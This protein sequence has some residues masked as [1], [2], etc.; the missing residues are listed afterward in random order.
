MRCSSFSPSFGFT[1]TWT[2]LCSAGLVFAMGCPVSAQPREP[3]DPS[4]APVV[5]SSPA[6]AP[7]KRAATQDES[8][9]FNALDLTRP[10][11]AAVA[12]AVNAGDYDAASHAWAVYLRERKN[13]YWGGKNPV[14][15]KKYNVKAADNAVNGKVQGGMVQY[16]YAF[17]D[18]KID[19]LY[20][21]TKDNPGQ[22]FNHEWQW[23]L[24][25]MSFWN[26]MANAYYFTK[27]ERYPK[28]FAQQLHSWM[29]QCPVPAKAK[30][31]PFDAWR[32]IEAGIRMLGSFPYT[33][34]LMLPS[35]SL[36]DADIVA[37]TR[38]VYDHSHYL[39]TNETSGNWLLM[40]MNGLCTAG[41][42]FPEFRDAADW[43]AHAFE[44][45]AAEAK[46]QLLPDGAQYELSTGYHPDVVISN[47]I[48]IRETAI[49]TGHDNEVP[50]S[51]LASIE[52]AYEWT[53]YLTTPNRNRPKKNDSWP[54]D[55]RPLMRKAFS[56]YPQRED[57][58]WF[59]TDGKEGHAPEKT[60]IFLDWSGQVVQRSGWEEDANYLIFNV[61]PLG[62]GHWHQDKL[63][64]C[65]WSHGRELLY[66]NGGS[67]YANDKWRS[68]SVNTFSHNCIL[69]D[70]LGQNRGASD[71][72]LSRDRDPNFVSQA[73]IQA[74]WQSTPV[75]DF[76]TGTYD[77]P[78]GP[79]K[80]RIAAQQR[81]VLFIKPDLYIVADRMTPVDA[82]PHTYQARWQLLSTE[83]AQDPKTAAV[84]TVDA[85]QPNLA[86]VPL[87]TSGLEVRS[88]S[89]Q[90]TPEILGWN[91]RKDMSPQNL[92]ATTVLH[93]KYAAGPQQFLTLLL[94]L[95][96][97]EKNPVAAVEAQAKYV[98]VRFADGR[99]FRISTAENGAIKVREVTKKG[100]V[101]RE[102]NGAVPAPAAEA[103]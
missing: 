81:S 96:A 56:L 8:V 5:A 51:Y 26:D 3:K 39:R 84:T 41:C 85:G 77:D 75:Y 11:L 61:A 101:I 93:T 95:K 32:T 14:V 42:Y 43:R 52:K 99:R 80:T 46:R 82:E 58:H 13:L 24:N 64:V 65:I 44:R 76:A 29:E 9:L 22:S 50:A 6:A 36:T 98:A 73:P 100:K 79:Q 47:F 17:P 62:Y 54:G 28:A 87:I 72:K 31:G 97:D 19:W 94:P 60:S 66:D 30:N 45:M 15:P 34:F 59:A 86:V 71:P 69:V 21:A 68:W 2:L 57:F 90:E 91:C 7:A 12:A 55:V 83:T 102:I 37:F 35:P 16:T 48:G 89:A 49:N 67:S 33:F 63:N 78:Y 53:M 1:Q 88:A 92:P 74:N 23:Q 70:G 10:E 40:E 4:S 38:S 18:G 27:D 103:K 20:N 25:R